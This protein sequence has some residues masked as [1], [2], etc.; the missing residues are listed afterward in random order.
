M[1][2]YVTK[3]A[4]THGIFR[5]EAE[6][7]ETDGM[8]CVKGSPGA[9]RQYFHGKDWHH[10]LDAAVA[11]AELM[12]AKKIA[13]LKKAIKKLEEMTFTVKEVKP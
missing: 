6:E 8:A 7:T 11:H 1:T 9:M 2:I 5:Q 12:R 4:L 3:Y 13:S 10:T